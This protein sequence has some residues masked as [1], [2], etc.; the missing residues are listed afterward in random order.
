MEAATLPTADLT[1][2][3]EPWLAL[4]L[5]EAPVG[6]PAEFLPACAAVALGA[7]LS[8]VHGPGAAA[9]RS[10]PSGGAKG[11][12]RQP[13]VDDLPTLE[14]LL[15]QAAHDPR[16]RTR[17]GLVLGLQAAGERDG[18][19]LFALCERWMASGDAYLMRAV[20]ATLAHSPILR[21]AGT[22]EA[23]LRHART[24]VDWLQAQPAA[25]RSTEGSRTLTQALGFALSMYVAAAPGPGFRLLDDLLAGGDRATRRIVGANLGKAR[26]AKAFPAQ[27][28]RLKGWLFEMDDWQRG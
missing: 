26:L 16:W 12:Q 19:H 7:A 2:L 20:L 4:T 22:A 15:E 8:T 13:S 5:D 3:V 17:E 28:S 18:P 10:L 25:R 11:D 6:S 14:P 1:A 24:A 9:A 23:A 21:Q 27:V